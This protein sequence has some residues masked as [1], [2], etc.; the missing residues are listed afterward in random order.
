[1][2]DVS[3]FTLWRLATRHGYEKA[4]VPVDHPHV[5]NNELIIKRDGDD[6]LHASFRINFANAY[7]CYYHIFH[8]FAFLGCSA[9]IFAV[10][11]GIPFLTLLIFARNSCIMASAL[12]NTKPAVK[13]E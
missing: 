12:C 13:S 6:R 3:E 9:A 4:I 8:S 11:A 10:D 5:M 7:I 1:M 2:G